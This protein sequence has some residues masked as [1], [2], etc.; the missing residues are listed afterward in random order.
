MG[1]QAVDLGCPQPVLQ[2][3]KIKTILNQLLPRKRKIKGNI[4]HALQNLK[5][6]ISSRERA[7]EEESERRSI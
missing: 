7:Y 4:F 1:W 2:R 5:P 3:E 6:D